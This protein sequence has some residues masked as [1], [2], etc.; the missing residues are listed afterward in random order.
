MTGIYEHSL[1]AYNCKQRRER[2]Q[3]A[4]RGQPKF[5]RPVSPPVEDEDPL[6]PEERN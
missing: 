2:A 5:S 3:T 6:S 4:E 1:S